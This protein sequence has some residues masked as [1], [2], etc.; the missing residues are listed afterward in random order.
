M[1]AVNK[2]YGENEPIALLAYLYGIAPLRDDYGTIKL[3]LQP[4]NEANVKKLAK[5]TNYLFVDKATKTV[6]LHLVKYKTSNKHGLISQDI[7]EA[8]PRLAKYIQEHNLA[9]DDYLFF[10]PQDKAKPLNSKKKL[11]EYVRTTLDLAKPIQYFRKS[12]LTY[13]K[14]KNIGNADELARI[15]NIAGHSHDQGLHYMRDE[16]V[17]DSDDEE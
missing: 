3:R 16:G 4:Y 15:S 14:N 9:T 1:K 13:L 2:K 11:G 6:K 10:N 7:S 12:A 5:E 8:Y 17:P